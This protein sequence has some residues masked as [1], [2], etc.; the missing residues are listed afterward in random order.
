MGTPFPKASGF[1]TALSSPFSPRPPPIFIPALITDAAAVVS[2]LCPRTA[3]AAEAL[4]SPTAPIRS[5]RTP[6]M[7]VDAAEA[8]AAS[9]A[10]DLRR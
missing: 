1:E 7:D 10:A 9:T 3:A 2:T 5:L 6:T 4:A 8:A